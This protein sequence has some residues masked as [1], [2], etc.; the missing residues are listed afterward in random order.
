M[1]KRAAAAKILVPRTINWAKTP[2]KAVLQRN[3]IKSSK[4][5]KNYYGK[6]SK[7][8]RRSQ[9]HCDQRRLILHNSHTPDFSTLVPQTGQNTVPSASCAP[10]LVHTQD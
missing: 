3:K 1:A 10:Q 2:E 4:K 7:S 5:S 8:L 9:L 6:D